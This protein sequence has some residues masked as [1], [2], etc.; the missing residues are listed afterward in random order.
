MEKSNCVY[1]VM[2]DGNFYF[3]L[4]MRESSQILSVSTQIF[5]TLVEEVRAEEPF[6]DPIPSSELCSFGIRQHLA[7]SLT[8]N[9]D[10]PEDT[11]AVTKLVATG[12][13]GGQP[14]EYK[15]TVD[16]RVLFHVLILF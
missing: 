14:T 2:H 1:Q 6:I 15:H 5:P 7:S 11:G 12:A 16:K 9:P 4:Q 13:N 3:C 8:K 10:C